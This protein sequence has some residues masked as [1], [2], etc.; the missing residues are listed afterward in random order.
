M[1]KSSSISPAEAIVI[2]TT[3]VVL[4]ECRWWRISRERQ[5]SLRTFALCLDLRDLI[6]DMD[7]I[8]RMPQA[9]ASQLRGELSG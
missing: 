7:F 1:A 6:D 2:R 3:M 5:E 9:T 8:G 4:L